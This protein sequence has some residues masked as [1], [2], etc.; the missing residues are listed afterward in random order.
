[1]Y[2]SNHFL[3]QTIISAE[4]IVHMYEYMHCNW[5]FDEITVTNQH[6]Q[7]VIWYDVNIILDQSQLMGGRLSTCMYIYWICVCTCIPLN[8]N[9]LCI[10]RSIPLTSPQFLALPTPLTP[11]KILI[12]KETMGSCRCW[13]GEPEVHP[14]NIKQRVKI[15]LQTRINDWSMSWINQ[16][17][18]LMYVPVLVLLLLL[19][20]SLTFLTYLHVYAHVHVAQQ[21]DH[22]GGVLSYT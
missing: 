3:S 8:G 6:T 10:P 19:S 11:R 16:L 17:H 7:Q 21:L 2:R 5:L 1:M 9:W 15:E 12:Q 18:A 13:G 20:T 22:V 14:G 4:V